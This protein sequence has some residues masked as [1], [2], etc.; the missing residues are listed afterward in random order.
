MTDP[1][2]QN[3]MRSVCIVVPVYNTSDTLKRLVKECNS[4][5]GSRQLTLIL[6]D[7]RSPDARTW[8]TVCEL[9]KQYNNL[10]GIRLLKNRGRAAAVFCGINHVV[11]LDR[12]A[13]VV[14]MDDDLQ[15]DPNDI[16][17]LLSTLQSD[18]EIDVAVAQFDSKQ[19]GI[20]ARAGS[21]VK[22]LIDRFYYGLPAELNLTSFI[23]LTPQ[24]ARELACIESSYPLFGPKLIAVAG[25]FKGVKCTHHPRED[26]APG[27]TFAKRVRLFCR[28]LFADTT[29]TLR[30]FTNLGI[31]ISIF[32]FLAGTL[33]LIRRLLY[34]HTLVGWTSLFVTIMFLGGL[35]MI[36]CG[37]IGINVIRAKENVEKLP[38]WSER[39]VVGK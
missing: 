6:V 39:D 18:P 5:L 36:L 21:R 22:A 16:P 4:V 17:L 10:T 31:A 7:D 32:S 9:S 8:K 23:A 2:V 20:I 24:V 25:S 35:N 12:D 29:M 33:V 28:I 27:F 11:K 37:L 1:D 30:L 19:H 3:V 15:H 38:S 14:I 13:L 26:G 34:N